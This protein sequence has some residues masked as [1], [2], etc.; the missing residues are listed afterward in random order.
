MKEIKEELKKLKEKARFDK[1]L[2]NYD[3]LVKKILSFEDAL[4]GYKKIEEIEPNELVKDYERY[5]QYASLLNNVK[6]L[7]Y[8]SYL[9]EYIRCLAKSPYNLPTTLF[10][11]EGAQDYN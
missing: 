5:E 6:E 8:P 10:N 1:K 4:D 7:Q 3:D 9:Y 11:P 2:G